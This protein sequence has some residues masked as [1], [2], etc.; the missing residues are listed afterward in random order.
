M[1]QVEDASCSLPGESCLLLD[2]MTNSPQITV[3]EIDLFSSILFLS[4]RLRYL[5]GK[6][7]VPFP[8]SDLIP[9]PKLVEIN[10]ETSIML[11]NL[12]LRLASLVC[13]LLYADKG[14]R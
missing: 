8:L 4:A 7:D 3:I 14:Q 9:D 6:A 11:F 13:M 1:Q 5:C 12:G 2:L 10:R